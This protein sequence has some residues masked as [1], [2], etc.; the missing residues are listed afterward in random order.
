MV[1]PVTGASHYQ[2]AG[3]VWVPEQGPSRQVVTRVWQPNV[4]TR[5]VPVTQYVARQV[6]RK[7]PVQVCRY[8]DEQVVRKV[9][10][11]VCRMVQ[12]EHVRKVPYQVCR[13]RG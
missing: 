4:V 3:L 11:Q 9:P 1:D 13:P 5:Q 8:V 2:R 6:T 12:E 7:V 10:Y